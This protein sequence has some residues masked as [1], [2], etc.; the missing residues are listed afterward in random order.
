MEGEEHMDVGGENIMEGGREDKV[1]WLRVA[2]T[3]D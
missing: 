3:L 2:L 1:T